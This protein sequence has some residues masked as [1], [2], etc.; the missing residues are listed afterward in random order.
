MKKLCLSFQYRNTKLLTSKRNE[1]WKLLW[2]S[3]LRNKF[4]EFLV[5]RL[6]K[7]RFRPPVQHSIYSGTFP[8]LAMYTIGRHGRTATDGRDTLARS[9]QEASSGSLMNWL[10]DWAIDGVVLEAIKVSESCHIVNYLVLLIFHLYWWVFIWYKCV[11]PRDIEL[12]NFIII[13]RFRRFAFIIPS[14]DSKRYNHITSH[15]IMKNPIECIY[16]QNVVSI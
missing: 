14:S 13:Y 16:L 5:N 4:P 7:H 11:M 2:E 1:F 6:I 8:I 12:L 9:I 3:T 15:N 10:R